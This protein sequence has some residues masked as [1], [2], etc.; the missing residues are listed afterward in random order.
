MAGTAIA[1][2]QDRGCGA[3]PSFKSVS[4]QQAVSSP[5]DHIVYGVIRVKK[6]G[7]KSKSGTTSTRNYLG[8]PSS[9]ARNS[10][11]LHKDSG[12]RNVKVFSANTVVAP[13]CALPL[14]KESDSA[15][16][17]SELT[18]HFALQLSYLTFTMGYF[19]SL[20]ERTWPTRT[21]FQTHLR[22]YHRAERPHQPALEYKFHKKLNALPCDEDGNFLIEGEPPLP[23]QPPPPD[24]WSP[25]ENRAAFEFAEFAFEK[26]LSSAED[27]N[28]QL[29]IWA[30]WCLQK[31]I[32]GTMYNDV[33]DILSHID[34]IPFGDAAWSSFDVRYTGPV[35]ENSPSWKRQTYTI[36]TRNTYEVQETFLK[37]QD[38]AK[39][40]D[41]VPYEAYTPEGARKWSN[42][43]SGRWAWKQADII[44]Q[45]PATHGAMLSPVILGS[46]KTTVSVATGNTEFHPVYMSCGNIHNEMRRG[47]CDAVV[48][49]AF[50]AI[51]KAARADE[52]TKEF[53]LFKKQLYHIS[54][55]HLLEPLRQGMTTPQVMRCPDGHFRRVIFEIGPFIADYPEQVLL[56]GIVQ[57]KCPKCFSQDLH[58]RGPPRCREITEQLLAGPYSDGILW[59]AFGINPGVTVRYSNDKPRTPDI[60]TPMTH[61]QPF[62]AN[63]PRADI[64]ELLSPDILHQLIK[65]TF[66]DHLVTW[67]EQYIKN[68]NAA[69][70]AKAILDDIDRRIAAV[71]SYPGL[72]RFPEGR[73]FKQWTG[74]D[75]KAL[76]KVLIPA[77]TGHV[78]DDMVRCLVAFTDFCYLA[79]RSSHTTHDLHAM[80]ESLQKFHG[81]RQI[82][83]EYDIRPDGFCL[84]R[85][86]ALQ[87]YVRS[88]ILFGSPN[89]L[90]SSITESKHITAVKKPWRASNHHNPLSQILRTNVRLSKISAQRINFAHRG[91]LHRDVLTATQIQL[92]LVDDDNLALPE[93]AYRERHEDEN[94]IDHVDGPQVTSFMKLASKKAYSGLSEELGE[95]FGCPRLTELC[96]RFLWDQIYDDEE[97]TSDDIDLEDCPQIDGPLHVYNSA[98]ATFYAPSEVSGPHDV[99]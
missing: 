73:K 15:I 84:P 52:N 9:V 4:V 98:S 75:S 78:P 44:A 37:N 64:H 56:A 24:D 77:I 62:T 79:R 96:R 1:T 18:S 68:D 58:T 2:S 38:F 69:E 87:H 57:G 59:D 94:E 26:S 95:R 72:R 3:G 12:C 41:Y 28:S 90:C 63:F 54:L 20:C 65:G 80:E 17:H 74:N 19:C 42:L 70:D 14:L 82:F 10:P 11:C 43:L 53:R 16:T 8:N 55:T 47:H 83:E 7:V 66:K 36:H 60:D 22:N 88:I 67:I 92:G 13:P 85:Q 97:L 39:A 31:G 81:L 34:E 5:A 89:G 91:M 40:F 32:D 50:L 71:P 45:D 21:G 29:R 48:P 23:Q 99:K 86:H 61:T 25:F 33:D 30:A 76:M 51:P 93:V 49:V 35:D 27:L 46:D 6:A